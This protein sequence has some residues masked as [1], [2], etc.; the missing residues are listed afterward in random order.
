MHI[1][2]FRPKSYRHTAVAYLMQYVLVLSGVEVIWL[3]FGWIWSPS[4]NHTNKLCLMVGV[5]PQQD[6]IKHT[7][8]LVAQVFK[9]SASLRNLP[10]TAKLLYFF[11]K[12]I[13]LQNMVQHSKDCPIYILDYI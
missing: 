2:Y 8:S 6:T 5:K 7:A 9:Y 12:P 10:H 11:L 1:S 13:Y 3:F 4:D